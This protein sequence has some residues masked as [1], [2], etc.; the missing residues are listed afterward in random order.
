LAITQASTAPIATS[1]PGASVER[2]PDSPKTPEPAKTEPTSTPKTPEAPASVNTQSTTPPAAPAGPTTTTPATTPSNAAETTPTTRRQT[3]AEQTLERT[4]VA[5]L[6]QNARRITIDPADDDFADLVPLARA[7]GNSRV[8]LLGEQTHGDGATFLAKSRII[9]FL[10]QKLGFDVLVF[11]S[12]LYDLARVNQGMREEPEWHEAAKRGVFGIWSQSEQCRPLFEYIY[13]SHRGPRPLELAGVDN[14]FTYDLGRS[15]FWDEMS[16][17]FDRAA[18]FSPRAGHLLDGEIADSLAQLKVWH[19]E[20]GFMSNAPAIDYSRLSEEEA[21]NAKKMTD[22]LKK[23]REGMLTALMKMVAR[24]DEDLASP[25]PMLTRVHSPRAVAFM[26]RSII[27]LHSYTRLLML[28][29]PSKLEDFNDANLRDLMMGENLLWLANEYYKDRRII[30]WAA[31]MH[32]ARNIKTISVSDQPGFYDRATT[33]GEVALPVLGPAAY[34]IMFTAFDGSIGRPWTGPTPIET[35]ARESLEGLL[36]R[37]NFE[38]AFLDFRGLPEKD[39]DGSPLWLRTRVVS[40][41]LGHLQMIAA[42]PEI[43]DGLIFTRTMTPSTQ[44]KLPIPPRRP[45]ENPDP[46][47]EERRGP[48][49]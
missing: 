16:E 2:E 25:D 12:G 9:K 6:Q 14:Q 20:R 47:V 44:A 41:P 22:L 35:A 19:M 18:L 23:Q 8:V 3:V 4:R 37:A 33:M 34:S 31:S 10:H 49:R 30:V 7:I 43:F 36:R 24:I 42:W 28:G 45:R 27:N 32:N 38:N 39:D 17:F 15:P 48:Q 29:D 1:T 46:D 5:W 13:A 40:R 11:E 26:R 21:E